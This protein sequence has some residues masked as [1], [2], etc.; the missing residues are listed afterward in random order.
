LEAFRFFREDQILTALMCHCTRNGMLDLEGARQGLHIEAI[1][2]ELLEIVS[3]V[4]PHDERV[5]SE[6]ERERADPI[7]GIGR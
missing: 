3:R 2:V 5:L 1:S 6:L 4:F 7:Y